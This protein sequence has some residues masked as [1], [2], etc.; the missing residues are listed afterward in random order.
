MMIEKPLNRNTYFDRVERTELQ[1][2]E[3]LVWFQPRTQPPRSD[4]R[5]CGQSRCVTKRWRR[6]N[7]K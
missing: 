1:C 4:I 3:C 5:T 2:P 6:I 7:G